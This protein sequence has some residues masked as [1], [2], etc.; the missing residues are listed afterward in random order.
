MNPFIALRARLAGYRFRPHWIPTFICLILLTGLLGLGRWQWQRA[1]FKEALQNRFLTA[2]RES[3]VTVE[4]VVDTGRDAQG[5]PIVLQGVLDNTHTVLLDNQMEGQMP[6]VHVLTPLHTVNG[7]VVL[8]NRGWMPIAQGAIGSTRLLPEVPPARDGVLTLAGHVYFPS[9]K[10]LILKEDDYS[11]P[12]WP[13]LVQ[14]LDLPAMTSVL[15]GSGA[16][17]ELAPFIVRVDPDVIVET[18]QQMPRHWQLMTMSP[19][20]HRA[21]AFQWY[22]LALTLVILY[23]VF[24]CQQVA[25]A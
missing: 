22:G 1:E 24:S 18:A 16:G 6:G 4:T 13:L 3:I 15:G 7:E 11:K 5:L 25:S 19:A 20:K 9:D 8:V 23:V 10:Q 12:R 21:Y 17:V 14:K 2:S